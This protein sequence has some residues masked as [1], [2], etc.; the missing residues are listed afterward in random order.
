MGWVSETYPLYC[1][2]VSMVGFDSCFF[3]GERER[4]GMFTK[5][6]RVCC[7]L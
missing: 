5:Y 4:E 7:N 1:N 2:P 6:A 3:F